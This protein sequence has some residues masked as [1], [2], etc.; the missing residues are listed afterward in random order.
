ME[1]LMLKF[2]KKKQMITVSESSKSE[3]EKLGFSDIEIVYNGIDHKSLTEFL[4]LK[5]SDEPIIIYLGRLKKYKRVDH[6]IKAF[7]TV[8]NKIHNVK[9][10]IVGLGDE[11]DKLEKL[12]KDL[13][14]NDVIFWGYASEKEKFELLRRAWIYVI[15][16]EKEGFGISVIEAN[17]LETPVV[18]YRVPGLVD[19]IKDGYNG[20]LVEDGDIEKLAV[21]LVNLLKNDNLRKKLSKNA[22]EWAKQFSWDRSAEEF[23]RVLERVLQ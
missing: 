16:S 2:Y 13:K 21:T 14:L 17:A 18:G 19:S 1:K 11:K 9:L 7:K 15:C 8:K 4:K 22:I 23:E 5:K 10:W 6:I 12:V 20:L 3:L